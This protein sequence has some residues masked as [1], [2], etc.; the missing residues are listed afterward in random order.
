MGLLYF[1]LY[2]C[3]LAGL[4][5]RGFVCSDRNMIEASG[6]KISLQYLEFGWDVCMYVYCV[7]ARDARK[8]HYQQKKSVFRMEIY[9]KKS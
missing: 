1:W 8:Y 2:F 4:I 9:Q 7:K 3:Y 6:E 5:P